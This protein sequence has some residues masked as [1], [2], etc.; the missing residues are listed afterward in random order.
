V[1]FYRW[2]RPV[3]TTIMPSECPICMSRQENNLGSL[4]CGHVMHFA[5]LQ[6]A[7][8]S[9]REC[10]MCRAPYPQHAV[11]IQRLFFDCSRAV[12][13]DSSLDSSFSDA[14]E[15][16]ELNSRI[17]QQNKEIELLNSIIESEKEANR[18]MLEKVR[19]LTQERQDAEKDAKASKERLRNL[20]QE[21]QQNR[22]TGFEL[23]NENQLL[24]EREKVFRAQLAAL[25]FSKDELRTAL[26]NKDAPKE[27]VVALVTVLKR[28]NTDLTVRVQKL[29]Q[30]VMMQE[31]RSGSALQLL[32]NI[33][34]GSRLD[35]DHGSAAAALDGSFRKR[36]RIQNA[37]AS[38]VRDAGPSVG[39][40]QDADEDV[41][42]GGFSALR[43]A[44]Q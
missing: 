39:A 26:G 32:S 27:E 31:E 9:K 29:E 38:Y 37:V 6:T 20:D 22:K 42:A 33:E 16:H 18:G 15:L 2:L 36:S 24:K 17:A 23:Q 3:L 1:L 41:S 11:K 10:P 12:G 44:R 13:A 14:A 35:A 43:L 25:T 30:D 34:R 40:K 8:A 5:C 4:P 28:Q 19:K 21:Y 7:F